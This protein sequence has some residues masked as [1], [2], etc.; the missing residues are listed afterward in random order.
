MNQCY[1]GDYITNPYYILQYGGDTPDFGP[2]D[3]SRKNNPFDQGLEYEN[4][5]PN[6]EPPVLDAPPLQKIGQGAEIDPEPKLSFD[7][8]DTGEYRDFSTSSNDL[9]SLTNDSNFL[10]DDSFDPSE[11]LFDNDE[12]ASTGPLDFGGDSFTQGIMDG[13]GFSADNEFA[14]PMKDLFLGPGDEGSSYTFASLW[15]A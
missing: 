9:E 7:L 8:I 15:R 11:Y 1:E 10:I 5:C 6:P 12:V 3:H 13:I 2:Q 4:F 14:D